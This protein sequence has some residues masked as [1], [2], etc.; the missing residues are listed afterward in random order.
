VTQ[1]PDT[2]HLAAQNTARG[3]AVLVPALCFIVMITSMMQTA[4][5]PLLRAIAVQ[6]DVGT[7][8]V[9]WTVTANLL[10]AAVCTPLLGHLADRHGPRKVMLAVLG[11]V[12]IGSVLCVAWTGLPALVAGRILQGVSYAL[13]PVGVAVVRGALGPHRV[14]M[15]LGVMSGALSVGGGAGMIAAGVLYTEG[16][17]YR[18]VF[19]MLL[20][21]TVIAMVVGWCVIP[22]TPGSGARDGFD[23]WGVLGLAIGLPGLLFALVQGGTWG[24]LSVRTLGCAVTGTLV[25][26]AWYRHERRTTTPLVAPALLT[27]RLV[28]PAHVAAFLVGVAMFVQFLAVAT[29]VQISRQEAGYGFDASVLETSLVYLLPG[30]IAGTAAAAVSGLV[31]RR[32]PAHRVLTAACAVGVCGFVML[33]LAH[34][35]T[36]QLITAV[37]VINVFVI[38]AYGALP[39]ML[40]GSVPPGNTGAVNGINAIARTFGSSLASA[41]VAVL[42]ATI[43]IPGTSTPT[44]Q[45]YILIFAVG[46]A[47]AFAAGL[48]AVTARRFAKYKT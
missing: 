46:G 11:T 30:Q 34:D 10:A 42:L 15:A 13:F 25:L 26:A 21:L 2:A 9:G 32:F 40:I 22:H 5:V 38:V 43:T 3:S 29:F 18:R 28:A 31:T 27:A 36:W 37:A 33:I 8:A 44:E 48:V 35:Y 17:D 6:L 7:D 12:L 24:W 23:F 47:A 45:A 1:A 20:I 39:S 14:P 19:W 16:S 4:V 41:V